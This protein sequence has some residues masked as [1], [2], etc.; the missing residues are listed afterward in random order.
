MST[1]CRVQSG[2]P[3]TSGRGA[4]HAEGRLGDR[5]DARRL[6]RAAGTGADLQHPELT[7]TQPP[8]SLLLFPRQNFISKP[9]AHRRYLRLA[10]ATRGACRPDAWAN[11]PAGSGRTARSDARDR[12]DRRT[13]YETRPIPWAGFTAGTFS[14][15]RQTAQTHRLVLLGDGANDTA[16]DRRCAPFPGCGS[17]G[18]GDHALAICLGQRMRLV[19]TSPRRRR[20]GRRRRSAKLLLGFG[21]SVA[22]LDAFLILLASSEV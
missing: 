20:Q 12:R 19:A 2:V 15:S 8:I 3:G 22:V 18:R 13:G 17:A 1:C 5:G 21:L 10:D 16:A 4:G 14:I 11:G 7:R 6:C 9:Y